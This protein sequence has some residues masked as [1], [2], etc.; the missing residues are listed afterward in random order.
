M[1]LLQIFENGQTIKVQIQKQRK[2]VATKHETFIELIYSLMLSFLSM[3]L[4]TPPH[5]NNLI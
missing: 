2:K 1:N 5:R 4:I 3:S